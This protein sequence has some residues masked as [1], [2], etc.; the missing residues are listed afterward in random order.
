MNTIAQM[1]QR[2]SPKATSTTSSSSSSGAD[3][4]K[5]DGGGGKRSTFTFFNRARTLSNS[6]AESNG[7][8]GGSGT[9]T[10]VIDQQPAPAAS[11]NSA[12]NM[13]PKLTP[14]NLLDKV[15]RRSHSDAKASK[16][17]VEHIKPGAFATAVS[18]SASYEQQLQLH[19]QQQL[20]AQQQQQLLGK[21]LSGP[22]ELNRAARK[23]LG[24]SICEENDDPDTNGDEST[25]SSAVYHPNRHMLLNKS[26]SNGSANYTNTSNTSKSYG[27]KSSSSS[28]SP[29]H[30]STQVTARL[31]GGAVVSQIAPTTGRTRSESMPQSL[32]IEVC[33][34]LL[35]YLSRYLTKDE[36]L[37]CC[38]CTGLELEGS[39]KRD[40]I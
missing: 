31:R 34:L 3:P 39:A 38:C 22:P 12:M 37:T 28:S 19:L 20:F 32:Y 30:S 17:T 7:S 23:H 16:Q 8:A 26:N 29:A 24:D 40:L 33:L 27:D 5:S 13:S 6:S 36:S 14:R 2:S 15:R 1:Q 10:T 9:I 11:S 18:T 4:S 35:S 25:S 21:R